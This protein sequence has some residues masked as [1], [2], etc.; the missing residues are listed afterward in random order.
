M[1][2]PLGRWDHGEVFERF[3]DRAR[4]V[5]VLAQEE[6]RL[7]NHSFIGTEHILL[8]L[9]HEGEGVAARALQELD[10]SLEAAREK[11]EESIGL[12]GTAP[13][14]SPPFTP[15]AKKVLELALREALQLGHNYI[16]TEHLLLGLVREGE[17]VAA[18]VLVSLGADLGSV[19][20]HVIR[21]LS[22]YGGEESGGGL[23]TQSESVGLAVTRGQVVECS[24]CGRRPPE[25]GQI[26]SGS[27]RAYICEHCVKEWAGRLDGE[28]E[29]E[30]FRHGAHV[31]ED[32][33]SQREN[34]PDIDLALRDDPED[35]T[36]TMV[37]ITGVPDQPGVVSLLFR[38]LA[39]NSV[40]VDRIAYDTAEAG[41][42]EISFTVSKATQPAFMSAYGQFHEELLDP[43]GA[44]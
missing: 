23:V 34:V 2:A 11:I 21:L 16:G 36:R 18:Q 29:D 39:D 3:T 4:R 25:S 42:L 8:G 1:A 32:D 38:V 31:S 19:R 27:R 5:L 10:I 30:P 28:T 35:T 37:R 14:G 22:G 41:I 9:I 43:G 6:A 24:F 7:L 12:S 33:R 44:S 20:Q 26:I 40:D 13:A 17:G 15:R